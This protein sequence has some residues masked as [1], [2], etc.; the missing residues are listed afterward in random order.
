MYLQATLQV[1]VR[2]NVRG[3]MSEIKHTND[4]LSDWRS[5]LLDDD[6]RYRKCIRFGLEYSE[7]GHSYQDN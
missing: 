1:P 5:V 7:N 4:V 6:G 3:N 2:H